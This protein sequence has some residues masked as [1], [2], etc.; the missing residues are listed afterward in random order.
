[1]IYERRINYYETDK[2]GITHHSNYIRFMEEARVVYLEQADYSYERLESEGYFSP[3]L[4][5][6]CRYENSTT[7]GDEIRINVNVKS[8]KGARFTVAYEAVKSSDGSRVFSGESEHCFIDK[9][10]KPIRISKSLPGLYEKMML[11]IRRSESGE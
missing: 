9:S 10:G 3:V 4:A 2:M 1:M 8:I 5:L 6:S 7:F 11:E